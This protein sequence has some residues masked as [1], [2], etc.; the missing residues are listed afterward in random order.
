MKRVKEGKQFNLSGLEGV[1]DIQVH[2]AA[3]A[4]RRQ[5]WA[6]KTAPQPAKVD[7]QEYDDARQRAK[8]YGFDPSRAL[9]IGFF[10]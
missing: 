8:D 4:D 3:P 10:D 6:K 5:R 2:K 1:Y 7:S 9:P